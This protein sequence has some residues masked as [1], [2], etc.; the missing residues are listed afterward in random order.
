MEQSQ[1]MLGDPVRP[2]KPAHGR[3]T[4]AQK[5]KTMGDAVLLD[6]QGRVATLT[7]NRPEQLNV[8]NTEL[9]LGLRQS[10]QV[11]ADDTDVRAVILTGQG[12]A[13]S[14]GGDIKFFVSE[15]Q[16]RTIGP[17]F[18]KMMPILHTAIGL[19]REMQKP[20]IA[21][22]NGVAAGGGLGLALACD[23]RIVSAKAG[24]V[25]AFLGIGASPDSSSTFFLPRFVGMG[26]ATALFMRN[27]PVSAQEALELGLATAVVPPENVLEEATSLA[28]ELAQGPTAAFG[29]TKLLL[30]QSFGSSFQE[31][32]HSEARSITI[33]A[34]S[35]D[36]AEGVTAF[37]EKRKPRFQ[38]K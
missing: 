7:L 24:L 32:L 5:E 36:F 10:L 34:Q 23:F 1:T 28:D 3:N 25:T 35:P 30:N 29:R 12:R 20:V 17:S 19:V 9:S 15:L 33:S 2:V 26:R 16:T 11:C 31:Q 14:G 37:V 22:L 38:G 27:T 8:M 4:G 13:F 18:E 6:R 21:A